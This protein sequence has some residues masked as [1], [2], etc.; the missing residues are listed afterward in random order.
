MGRNSFKGQNIILGS[1]LE[2]ASMGHFGGSY[3][4]VVGLSYLF[5]SIL[6]NNTFQLVSQQFSCFDI[7]QDILP[8]FGNH[9]YHVFQ[10]HRI[11]TIKSS[12][13]FF[14]TIGLDAS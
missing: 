6:G 10:D 11:F 5:L 13:V 1:T 3:D 9:P 7:F 8:S 2:R 4:L 12:S 14:Q